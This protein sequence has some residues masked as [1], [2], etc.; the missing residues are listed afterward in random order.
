MKQSQKSEIVGIQ[1]MITKEQA[2][3]IAKKVI[4]D[5]EDRVY[6]ISL[7]KPQGVTMY[8]GVPDDCWYLTYSYRPKKSGD[9]TNLSRAIFINK[10]TGEIVFNDILPDEG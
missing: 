1:N 9:L 8:G 10:Y 7:E 6:G 3:E 4:P 2:I 5:L